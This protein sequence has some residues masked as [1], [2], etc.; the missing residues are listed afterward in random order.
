[1][2][3]N[4]PVKIYTRHGDD[5]TTGLVGTDRVAKDHVRV[6]AYGAVDELNC[7]IGHAIEACTCEAMDAALRVVQHELF[8]LGAELATP[9]GAA[10]PG[11]TLDER[12][13][14]TLEG[15]IDRWNEQLPPLRRFVLPGGCSLACR[16][17][18][19]R[20]VCRRAE[21][22]GVTL[23]TAEGISPTVVCYLNRFSDLL[24]VMARRANQLASVPDVE[25][26]GMG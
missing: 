21:R 9:A 13:V 2:P 4:V 8:V 7:H 10:P 22:R 14:H 24:F 1:M 18:L 3:Y 17:H 16:L 12:H 15:H 11:A 5:G 23:G 6:E 19:A 20:S 25:W 26:N